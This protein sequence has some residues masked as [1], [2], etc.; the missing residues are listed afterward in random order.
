MRIWRS[1]RGR[2]TRLVRQPG[3]L[4]GLPQRVYVK[5][6]YFDTG[7][8]ASAA[9][10][11]FLAQ[12]FRLRSC[13]DPDLTGVG[14]Q[15]RGFDQ[16]VAAGYTHYRVR[17]VKLFAKMVMDSDSTPAATDGCTWFMMISGQATTISSNIDLNEV[18]D[19]PLQ[20]VLKKKWMVPAINTSASTFGSMILSTKQYVKTELMANRFRATD[21]G[22]QGPTYFDFNQ[23]TTVGSNPP[24]ENDVYF[25]FGSVPEA[26]LA[27]A[28]GFQWF[29]KIIYYTEFFFVDT[30]GES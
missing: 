29:V 13:F 15:P 2:F 21:V 10:I 4:Q 9:T 11:S 30:P 18:G 14:H 27:T 25:T 1:K 26:D 19:S 3:S 22:P 8:I 20:V 23:Y 17:G 7:T 5:L 12:Q 6:P 24:A 28:Q 16:W